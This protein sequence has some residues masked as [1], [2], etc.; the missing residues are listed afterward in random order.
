MNTYESS[1]FPQCGDIVEIKEMFRSEYTNETYLDKKFKKYS[2]E[3][4]LSFVEN[5]LGFELRNSGV[6]TNIHDDTCEVRFF[7][8]ETRTWGSGLYKTE[9][10]KLSKLKKLYIDP[11]SG[12]R[13][14]FPKEFTEEDCHNLELWL[15][16]N[17]YPEKDAAFGA[18]YARWWRE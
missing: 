5:H 15:I 18:K 10:L 6:I 13:Y 2:S 1:L 3:E 8:K 11:P 12:W 4:F 7:C 17:G 9:H 14:G 16:A